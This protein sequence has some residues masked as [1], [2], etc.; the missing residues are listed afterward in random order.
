MWSCIRPYNIKRK[1]K[2]KFHLLIYLHD[3]K[4]NNNNNFF[5]IVSFIHLFFTFKI[6]NKGLHSC[7]YHIY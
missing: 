7:I 6:K 5:K 4:K 2:I 1:R 3:I